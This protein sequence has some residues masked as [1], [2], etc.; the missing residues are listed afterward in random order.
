MYRVEVPASFTQPYI[1]KVRQYM[2]YLTSWCD[3]GSDSQEN[4]ETFGLFSTVDNKVNFG[5]GRRG[6]DEYTKQY[7]KFKMV[8]GEK[9]GLDWIGC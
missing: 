9:A 2:D 4:N 8:Y 7:I 1:V 6:T 3:N 5:S